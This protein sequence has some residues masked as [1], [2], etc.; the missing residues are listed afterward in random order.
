MSIGNSMGNSLGQAG[1]PHASSEFTTANGTDYELI[2]G[3]INFP[4]GAISVTIPN[5]TQALYDVANHTCMAQFDGCGNITKY[6]QI[7]HGDLLVQ[8]FFYCVLQIDNVPVEQGNKIVTMIGRRQEVCMT[9]NDV[10]INLSQFLDDKTNAV[11]TR[12]TFCNSGNSDIEISLSMGLQGH[13]DIHVT[14]APA[15][16]LIETLE[17]KI[18]YTL[19]LTVPPGA[20]R[21]FFYAIAPQP[22]A[23]FNPS[24]FNAREHD[25]LD[26]IAHLKE[27]YRHSNYTPANEADNEK[28]RAMYISCINCALSAYKD[29]P[30]LEFKALFAGI[31]YQSPARTY[32]RDGYSTMLCLLRIAPEL[33]KNQIITL[34]RGVNKDGSCPSAVIASAQK[35][36]F[37]DGHYD[38]PAFMIIMVYDYILQTG[39]YALL[40][41]EINNL[42]LIDTL[43]NCLQ[44]LNTQTDGTGLIVKPP[45]CRL[46]WADNVY[47]E[48]YVTYI[49]ALYAQAV[50][51]MSTFYHKLGHEKQADALTAQYQQIKNAI[52]THLW[53]EAQGHYINYVSENCREDNL[54]LDTVFCILYNLADKPRAKRHLQACKQQLEADFGVRC[55]APIYKYQSHL[56][57]KSAF[58]T[59]YH[60][61][62]DW[63]YL[64]GLYA[65]ALMRYGFDA[66]HALTRWFEYSLAQ[67]WYTPVEYFSPAYGRGSLLQAWSATPAYAMQVGDKQSEVQNEHPYQKDNAPN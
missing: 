3:N 8:D 46:D 19:N 61:G 40:T 21:D 12:Y 26:Y 64:D 6:S 66:S 36:S 43:E 1:K 57:E 20:Q 5:L 50:Y 41:Q 24:Y 7:G 63:P 18:Y 10:D 51:A 15:L 9:I 47:R 42:P 54:S 25:A 11:F 17:N 34:A 53:D 2:S 14:S 62:S 31:A 55:V 29:I 33:I 4:D 49:E 32:Y 13:G 44:W 48:G 52:N 16:N 27:N 60:N 35:K 56:V 59:R 39:D 28:L 38:S 30:K 45:S 23:K 22:I 67:G 37:W 58:P 65:L